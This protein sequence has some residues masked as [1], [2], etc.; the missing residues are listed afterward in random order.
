MAS[1]VITKA[2]C[3]LVCKIPCFLFFVNLVHTHWYDVTQ[4]LQQ[5]MWQITAKCHSQNP[6]KNTS[7]LSMRQITANNEALYQI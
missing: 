7:H 4:N 6:G 3:Y 2:A 1:V 5:N